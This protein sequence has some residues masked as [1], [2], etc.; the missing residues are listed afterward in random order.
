MKH[1]DLAQSVARANHQ[2]PAEARDAIDELVHKILGS[3]E[4]GEPVELPGV[5]KL[6]TAPPKPKPRRKR[7]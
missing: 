7:R 6:V 3:L 4:R 5:G 2:S 1:E